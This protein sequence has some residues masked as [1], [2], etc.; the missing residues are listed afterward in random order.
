MKTF[1]FF[2]MTLLAP[3]VFA[4]PFGSLVEPYERGTRTYKDSYLIDKIADGKTISVCVDGRVDKYTLSAQQIDAALN[5]WF[6]HAYN[7]VVRAKR[8][9][10]FK[11]L[12][13]LLS[14]GAKIRMQNCSNDASFKNQ[15]A[16]IL[17]YGSG[18]DGYGYAS[19]REDLRIILV[20]PQDISEGRSYFSEGSSSS[21]AYVALS[22]E[23]ARGSDGLNVLRHELGHAL[24]LADQYQD[25][26]LN[27]SPDY[28]TSDNLP[29][30]MQN[31]KKF[32]CDDADA[33]I[34]TLDCIAEK[35][36]S[37]GGAEG[38]RSFCP[39]RAGRNYAYCKTKL[40]EDLLW[41]SPSRVRYARYDRQ[42]NV[43]VHKEWDLLNDSRLF[44]LY[45]QGIPSLPANL[46]TVYKGQFV[47]YKTDNY[48]DY[49]FSTRP[50]E[51][52][53]VVPVQP[54]QTL[55]VRADANYSVVVVKGKDSV[56][57][58]M[59]RAAKNENFS[60]K[61]Q[62][63]NVSA[64]AYLSVSGHDKVH[65]E[66]FYTP[67]ARFEYYNRGEEGMVAFVFPKDSSV[68][69]IFFTPDAS[70][71]N[72]V[73]TGAVADVPA[74]GEEEY[75]NFNIRPISEQEAE[76]F[77][78]QA[79]SAGGNYSLNENEF[80]PTNFLYRNT[81]GQDAWA[82]HVLRRGFVEGTIQNWMPNSL[83]DGFALPAQSG[84]AASRQQ[85]RSQVRKTLT[86]Q[87]GKNTRK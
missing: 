2:I 50:E 18:A 86:R 24:S 87:L 9:R 54:G 58:P 68:F 69:Y 73:V 51:H 77:L 3:A 49:L 30:M 4:A 34:F 17:D 60:F 81:L 85:V 23:D 75:A 61:K 43:K 33:L 39:Q 82:L 7:S 47:T 76:L 55:V 14:Q 25:S 40:R 36:T 57:V 62:G 48:A 5:S 11:D 46:Q 27:S 52:G 74:A 41:V 45:P 26:R 6:K 64:K 29:S 16:G 35:N 32:T 56:V 66:L 15:F 10:E 38:W 79:N 20:T 84:T 8:Q 53:D 80:F 67:Q 37:R 59:G 19:S 31:V 70:S 78:S 65:M 12:L 1:C 44:S 22:G 71:K 13:P 21:A 42:G 72:R 63:R 28:G 83:S